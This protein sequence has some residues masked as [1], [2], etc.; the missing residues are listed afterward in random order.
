[1]RHRWSRSRTYRNAHRGRPVGGRLAVTIIGTGAKRSN[2]TNA[3]RSPFRFAKERELIFANPARVDD[4]GHEASPQINETDNRR[5][6]ATTTQPQPNTT[7]TTT[8]V[9]AGVLTT[10]VMLGGPVRSKLLPVPCSFTQ[11]LLTPPND[12]K[13]GSTGPRRT[14]LAPVFVLTTTAAMLA[15]PVAGCGPR[16][17]CL[18]LQG[19]RDVACGPRLGLRI[20]PYH[21]RG[22]CAIRFSGAAAVGGV[23]HVVGHLQVELLK[24]GRPGG[25]PALRRRRCPVSGAAAVGG[26]S[27]VVRHLHVGLLKEAPSGGGD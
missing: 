19:F 21:W 10:T 18:S 4:T 2:A 1:M 12:V 3:L 13:G 14:A 23:S 27:H 22:R 7:L 15:S 25:S 26:V 16:F 20:V 8:V 5:I 17:L 9:A 24:A 11:Q 6:R